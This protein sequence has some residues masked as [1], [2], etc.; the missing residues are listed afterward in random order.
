VREGVLEDIAAAL[1]VSSSGASGIVQLRP[2]S[3][4]VRGQ[5]LKPDA[6]TNLV[7]QRTLIPTVRQEL[8]FEAT[9]GEE[10]EVVMLVVGVFAVAGRS[11]QDGGDLWRRWVDKPVVLLRGEDWKVAEECIVVGE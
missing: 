6:N 5:V 7:V 3:P 11:S 9:A 1:I 8:A 4:L 10:E 2:S